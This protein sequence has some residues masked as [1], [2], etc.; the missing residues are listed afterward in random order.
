MVALSITDE[1][2]YAFAQVVISA[3]A[4][5][6]PTSFPLGDERQAQTHD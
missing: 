4:L 3:V 1:Y 6:S 2:P 5:G